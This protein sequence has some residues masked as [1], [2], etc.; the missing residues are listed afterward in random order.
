M[1]SLKS[2]K[3]IAGLL[4]KGFR[5]SD[6]D[7]AFLILYVDDRRTRVWTKVSHGG[8]DIADPLINKM[9]KQVYLNKKN[10]V[11]LVNCPMTAEAYLKKLVDERI[12]L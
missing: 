2:Q 5:R 1:T 8:K 3:V 9:S 10:F 11:D 12:E 7:H 4:K 6:N